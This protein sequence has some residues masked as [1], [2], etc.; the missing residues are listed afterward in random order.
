MTVTLPRIRQIA[1]VS[2][3]LDAAC[4]AIETGLGL[5]EPF[6]DPAVAEFGLTNA[7]YELGDTFLEVV[8]P[9]GPGTAAGRYLERKGGDAGYMALFQVADTVATRRRSAEAGLRTV[10]QID[11]PDISGTHI[12][13]GAQSPRLQP[14][15]APAEAASRRRDGQL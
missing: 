7:V 10:W 12:H 11:L 14:R 8:S 3:D 15:A 2:V 13:E 4:D 9:A 5:A 6:H 1:L